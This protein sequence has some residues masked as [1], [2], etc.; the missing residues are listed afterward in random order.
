MPIVGYLYSRSSF[1][2]VFIE[3]PKSGKI[4]LGPYASDANHAWKID[5]DCSS[6]D[7]DVKKMSTEKGYD[8]LIINE[9][10]FS[11]YDPFEVKCEDILF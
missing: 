5:S 9:D 10:K 3:K 7:V 4:E 2:H 11:G 6:V 1:E 8:H